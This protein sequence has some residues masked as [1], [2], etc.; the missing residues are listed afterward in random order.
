MVARP[1][2]GSEIRALVS[3]VADQLDPRGDREHTVILVGGSL[4]AW[5]D[6]RESTEDVDTAR[7]FDEEVGAAVARVA[8]ENDLAPN[9]LNAKAAGFIPATFD[10]DACE[11][12]LDHPR[13]R[14]LGASLRDVL[15]MKLYRA[16]PNDV[17]DMIVMWPHIGFTSAA[18]VVDAFTAA[19]PHVAVDPHLDQLVI[20]IAAR[21]GNENGFADTH[22]EQPHRCCREGV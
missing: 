15:M 13:L 10:L 14:V 21:A 4:L 11:V 8:L 1:L 12:L 18:E 5:R 20:A 22:G 7:R 17:A 19:Y 3:Q 2:T 6:L 16:D 9:W